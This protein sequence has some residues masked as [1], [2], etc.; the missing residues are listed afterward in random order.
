MHDVGSGGEVV[1]GEWF[2]SAE[3]AEEELF[4]IW[5]ELDAGH[6]EHLIR[7]SKDLNEPSKRPNIPPSF[8]EK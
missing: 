7:G 1:D 6:G 4:V 3:E 5:T 2:V 8:S